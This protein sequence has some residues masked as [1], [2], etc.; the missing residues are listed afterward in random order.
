MTDAGSRGAYSEDALVEQPAIALQ[1]EIDA[2]YS[3]A[4]TKIVKI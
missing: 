2:L 4:E 1:E 3:E